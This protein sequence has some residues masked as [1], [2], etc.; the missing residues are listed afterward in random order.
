MNDFVE[1]VLPE[2]PLRSAM[3]GFALNILDPDQL[4][5][6]L[7]VEPMCGVKQRRA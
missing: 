6:T 4:D 7:N 3:V 1:I 5:E 2:A